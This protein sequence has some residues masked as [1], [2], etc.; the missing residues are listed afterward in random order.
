MPD[1]YSVFTSNVDGQ[2]Q[3]AGY[4]K[5]LIHECHGSIHHAQCIQPCNDEIWSL[6]D[7][8]PEV[9]VD[10]C[11]LTNA[12]PQC[13]YCDAIVR[14]NIYM[15]DDMSWLDSNKN[16]QSARQEKWLQTAS[17][18]VV[19]EIG[20]G[21]A[22]PTVRQFSEWIVHNY[23]GTLIRINPD[24]FE[25]PTSIAETKSVGISMSALEALQAIECR[26]QELL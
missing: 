9:D 15:F 25:V 22:I 24:E 11:Q 1:G 4:D 2:F 18:P 23:R 19:V 17:R 20:A 3:K 16:M 13:K 12:Y 7:F 21:S 8:Q 14:P 6:D 5:R 26:I 10:A